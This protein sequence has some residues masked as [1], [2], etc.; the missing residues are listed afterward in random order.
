MKKIVIVTDFLGQMYYELL[1]NIRDVLGDRVLIENCTIESMKENEKISGD[2]ILVMLEKRLSKLAGRIENP[3]NVIVVSRTIKKENA[4]GIFDIPENEPVLVVND[5]YETALQMTTLFYKW[6]LRNLKLIT[7][8]ESESYKDVKYA[9]VS[10][11]TELVPSHIKNIVD[12]GV[13][14][15]DTATLITIINKLGFHDSQVHQNLL[16]YINKIVTIEEGISKQYKDLYFE[17]ERLNSVLEKSSDGIL[18]INNKWDV[19]LSNDKA[20]DVFSCHI[21]DGHVNDT[22]KDAFEHMLSNGD[23]DHEVISFDQSYLMVSVKTLMTDEKTWEKLLIFNDITY[24]RKL[25]QTVSK[26]LMSTGLKA[27]YHFSDIIHKSSVMVSCLETAR[28]FAASDKT[29]LI[30]GESGTGKE[31]LAQSIHNASNRKSQPFVAINCAALPETLLESELFGYDPGAFTGANKQGKS[32]LF[33]Q[34]HNGTILL[35]EIGDMPYALQARLLRVIQERQV[36]RIGS[37]RVIDIDVRIIASTNKNLMDEVN[38]HNFREDLYYRLD[39]LPLIVPP[40]RDRKED[41][42]P[43]FMSL[44]SESFIHDSVKEALVDYDWRGNIRELR[45][46]SEYYSIMKNTKRPLPAHFYLK[47]SEK[48]LEESLL[49]LI[50]EQTRTSGGVGRSKLTKLLNESGVE[51]SEY[52]LRKTLESLS[53]RGLIEKG[54]GRAGCKASQEAMKKLDE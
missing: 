4:V 2:L 49:S 7:Y 44:I 26:K 37:D 50:I 11:L 42:I 21:H 25:E 32:G 53:H 54:L 20:K 22:F 36:M 6:K 3:D 9:I 40:L 19:L 31:L 41:I 17:S 5:Y 51:I 8:K 30:H 28:L 12:V 52:K 10:C 33:E 13:R 46:V 48:S 39:V 38:K 18:V 35:D 14:C 24:L 16:K 47:V 15:L 29:I 45:N 27:K 34:A 43:I 1:S 23:L